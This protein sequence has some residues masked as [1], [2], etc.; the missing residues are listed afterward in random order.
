MSAQSI[1]NVLLLMDCEDAVMACSVLFTISFLQVLV[2]HHPTQRRTYRTL[3]ARQH[4]AILYNLPHVYTY[5]FNI[6]TYMYMSLYT[7]MQT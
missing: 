3:L 1:L 5:C 7:F 4:K 2:F 6:H